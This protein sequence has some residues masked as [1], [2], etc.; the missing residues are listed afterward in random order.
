MNPI[1]PSRNIRRRPKMSPSRAPAIRNTANA[2]V[3]AALN[4]WIVLGPP[5]S[6]RW[7]D[8]PAT[9]TIVASSR[10]IVLAVS[11]TMATTQRRR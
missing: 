9:L 5:P 4:H 3:Y 11:T 7:M 1:K 2:R 8:G 6:P 10:S